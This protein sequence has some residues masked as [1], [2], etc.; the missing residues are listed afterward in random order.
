MP[1]GKTR[2]CHELTKKY[3]CKR[4]K[5]CVISDSGGCREN[6]NYKRP[7]RSKSR[8]TPKRSKS[9]SPKK[10]GYDKTTKRCKQGGKKRRYDNK[11]FRTCD[12]KG[13]RCVMTKGF[14]SYPYRLTKRKRKKRSTPLSKYDMTKFPQY[15]NSKGEFELLA[16][17][18]F[19]Y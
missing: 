1:R 14:R 5:T 17:S 6:K 13:T 8:R 16:K 10:C 15:K 4:R 12:K 9:R 7:S 18:P 19:K 11:Q 2:S 3:E